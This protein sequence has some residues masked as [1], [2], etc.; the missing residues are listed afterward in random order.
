MTATGDITAQESVRLGPAFRSEAGRSVTPAAE[1]ATFVPPS[2]CH[3]HAR[4]SIDS[5]SPN[6]F[7]TR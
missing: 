3:L 2:S 7:H 5:A 4:Q 1:R 6:W